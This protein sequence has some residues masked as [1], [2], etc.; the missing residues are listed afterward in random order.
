MGNIHALNRC[1]NFIPAALKLKLVVSLLFPHF[2]CCDTVLHDISVELKSKLQKVQNS[3]VRFA[4]NLKKF[5]QVSPSFKKLKWQKLNSTTA[6]HMAI[7]V[8]KSL[9]LDKFPS[10]LKFMFLSLSDSH[11]RSTRSKSNLTLKLPKYNLLAYKRSFAYAAAHL[12]NELPLSI[13]CAKSLYQFKTLYR[14]NFFK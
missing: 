1:R 8:Y 12:W 7:I 4:C 6:F 13:R 5:D 3:C 10:Y 11:G 2:N 9:H 14:A